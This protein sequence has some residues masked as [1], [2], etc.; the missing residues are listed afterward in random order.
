[1]VAQKS[2]IMN[3]K[4]AFSSQTRHFT[5]IAANG[6]LLTWGDNSFGSLGTGSNSDKAQKTPVPLALPLL[7][8]YSSAA[9]HSV[10]L[11]YDYQIYVWGDN[12]QSQLSGDV[13]TSKLTPSLLSLPTT[14]KP[15]FVSTRGSTVY[16]ITEDGSL[17]GLG[18][19]SSGQLAA[20][21]TVRTLST[22]TK[23]NLPSPVVDL[24]CGFNYAVA[25]TRDGSVYSWGDAGEGRLGYQTY[26]IVCTPRRVSLQNIVRVFC[27][28]G[29][30][31]ALTSEG[32]L[33]SWGWNRGRN[34]G[35]AHSWGHQ[36]T[37]IFSKGVQEVA[38]G[39][40]HTLALMDD[41]SLW[42]WGGNSSGQCGVGNTSQSENPEKISFFENMKVVGIITGVEFSAAITGD[43]DLYYWGCLDD[44][45]PTTTTPKKFED[46][47]VRIPC[48]RDWQNIFQWLFLGMRDKDSPFSH[49]PV[50]VLFHFVLA[51]YKTAMR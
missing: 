50:E 30:S 19:N 51:T 15:I 13:L 6:R 10:A 20:E 39:W 27:G 40:I 21:K 17:W 46:F 35:V 47:K 23:I 2:K 7:R 31:F 45:F 3:C 26:D 25:L 34:C 22:P 8:D 42:S 24:G 12:S 48:D 11:T 49:M 32:G 14:E 43:G 18:S 4:T 9:F 44:V 36:P 28:S 1:V 16:V 29:T 5:V 41:G 38:C 37:L 33:W